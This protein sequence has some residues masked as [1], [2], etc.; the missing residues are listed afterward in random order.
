MCAYGCVYGCVRAGVC[1]CVCVYGC[2]RTGVCVCVRVCAYGCVYHGVYM[3]PAMGTR[4]GRV[5]GQGE[6]GRRQWWQLWIARLVSRTLRGHDWVVVN[7]DA[8]TGHLQAMTAREE[9]QSDI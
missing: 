7:R 6:Q 4:T 3:G 9:G 5:V 8:V 2:V 1:V